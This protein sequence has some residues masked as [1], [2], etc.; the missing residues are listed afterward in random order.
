MSTYF[1]PLYILAFL[2]LLVGVF[3]LLSRIRG[4]KYARPVVQFLLRVPVVGKLLRR[5]STAALERQN[6][7]LASAVKKLERAGATQDPQRAQQA[8]SRLSAAERK[9]YLDAASEQQAMPEPMN[10][11]QRRAM[12]RMRKQGR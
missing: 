1:I 9:A 10:R 6:P 2:A 11:A 8:L 3:A 12:E 4:G 5:A 7:E